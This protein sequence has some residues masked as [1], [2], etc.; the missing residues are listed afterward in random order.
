LSIRKLSVT[1]FPVSPRNAYVK[2][3]R[4]ANAEMVG[5]RIHIAGQPDGPIELEIEI[6]SNGGQLS[7]TAINSKGELLMGRRW[8]GRLVQSRIY[9]D[10]TGRGKEDSHQ[11]GQPWIRWYKRDSNSI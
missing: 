6:G 2:S 8:A 1:G 4:A 3:F 11:W 5:N 9:G 7:G 10:S